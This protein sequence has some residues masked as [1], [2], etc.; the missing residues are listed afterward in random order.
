MGDWLGLGAIGR[1]T[2]NEAGA[3]LSHD[4]TGQDREIRPGR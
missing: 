2:A 3:V 4:A 1:R